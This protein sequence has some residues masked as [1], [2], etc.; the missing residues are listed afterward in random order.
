VEAVPPAP[1]GE[2]CALPVA[3]GPLPDEVRYGE[4]EAALGGE[5]VAVCERGVLPLG[6]PV[7]CRWLTQRLCAAVRAWRWQRRP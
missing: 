2:C 5:G 3:V 1:E 6:E 7:G 4:A